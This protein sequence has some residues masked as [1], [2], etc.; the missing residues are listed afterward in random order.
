MQSIHSFQR[1]K[2]IISELSIWEKPTLQ[3][4]LMK[5]MFIFSVSI[6]LVPALES[7]Y[8]SSIASSISTLTSLDILLNL[9]MHQFSHL[10]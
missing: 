9:S 2:E 8:W 6:N 4:E 3:R 1:Q 5:S 10:Q 7:D